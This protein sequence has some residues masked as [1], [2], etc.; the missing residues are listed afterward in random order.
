[1]GVLIV[2]NRIKLAAS[3][4]EMQPIDRVDRIQLWLTV[5]KAV[6]QLP[7]LSSR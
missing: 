7:R 4:A 2:R 3:S 1:M 5:P 6:S